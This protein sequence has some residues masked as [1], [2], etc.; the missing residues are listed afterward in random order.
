MSFVII[1][2]L[3]YA[4]FTSVFGDDFFV[5]NDDTSSQ[6]KKCFGSCLYKV[7]FNSYFLYLPLPFNVCGYFFHFLPHWWMVQFIFNFDERKGQFFNKE[8]N[9]NKEVFLCVSS[10]D[11]IRYDNISISCIV[12]AFTFVSFI[13]NFV[14]KHLF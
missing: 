13:N 1:W 4:T 6:K 8:N 5:K 11:T 2:Y 12:K 7:L 10:F 9:P 14:S 3:T